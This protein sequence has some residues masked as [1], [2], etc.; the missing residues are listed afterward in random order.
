[1]NA[2]KTSGLDSS[3][4]NPTAPLTQTVTQKLRRVLV[5]D[6]DPAALRLVEVLL[7]K[8][9]FDITGQSRS[10]EVVAQLESEHFDC[11]VTDAM[12]PV[13]D[14]YE[15][16]KKIRSIPRLKNLPIIMLTHKRDRNDI[17]RAVDAGITEY[18]FKPVDHSLLIAKIEECLSK[19][20]ENPS[21]QLEASVT[22]SHWESEAQ[23]LQTFKI[24][25]I[26]PNEII[27]QSDW[28]PAR[29]DATPLKLQGPIF[30][31]IG[32]DPPEL[33]VTLRQVEAILQE[34][35]DIPIGY[36]LTATYSD[37]PEHQ[38]MKLSEWLKVHR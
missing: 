33:S 15:L 13:L 32:L 34:G 17:K 35:E 16:T 10:T 25:S 26:F 2:V 29:I 20:T 22:P 8:A 23:A 19:R 30:R 1:M 36:R 7:S 37:L 5:V 28:A 14:G 18:V 27:L 4:S 38:Y 6:D 24:L 12:M 31:R 21:E 11:V 9:E 3:L